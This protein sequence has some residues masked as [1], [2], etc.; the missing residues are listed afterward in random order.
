[1]EEHPPLR[2]A[3]ADSYVA[4]RKPVLAVE[5]ILLASERVGDETTSAAL[6]KVAKAFPD[7]ARTY[8]LLG[9][10]DFRAGR[11]A[12]GVERYERVLSLSA[13]DGPI[14]VP[15]LLAVLDAGTTSGPLADCL[16]QVFLKEGDRARAAILLRH[17]VRHDPMS[18]PEV[19]KQVRDALTPEPAHPGM[20]IALSEA[21]LA[22]GEAVEAISVIGQL[23][24]DD[25]IRAGEVLHTLS[26][27]SSASPEAARSA[28]ALFREL[29]SREILPV[30]SR[31]GRGEAALNA[32]EVGEAVS[33]FRELASRAPERMEEI[34]GIFE[35]LL[36]RHPET[37]EVR[38]IL[39]G[40]YLD[41]K[42]FQGATAEL[43]KIQ[44]LNPDLLAPVLTK[45][46]EVL[47]VSPDDVEIRL[48][49]SAALLLS[50]QFEEVQ[51]LAAE[52]LRL[53]DDEATAPIQLD[54]GDACLE[55][56]DVTSAVKRYYNAYRKRPS[57]AANAAARLERVLDF[58]PN[59]ALASLALG[60]TLPET[61]RV[62]DAVARL[63]EAF[64]NDPR[65]SEGVLAEL[66]RIRAVHPVSPEAALARVD[67]LCALGRDPAATE[68]IV[69]V[70][71]SRPESARAMIPRL[72]SI[73]SRN[74]GHAPAFLALA[75][76][77]RGLEDIPHAAE[78][79]RSAY[80]A[81]RGAA[82]QVIR[83]CS[84][85]IS[86]DPKAAVPYLSM[87]EIYLADGEI[88]AATEKL[89]QAATRAEERQ[90]EILEILDEAT[91]R[92]SGTARVALLA[93]EILAR[94][95]R[96]TA[97]VRSFRKAL[98]RDSGMLET[99]L[100]G[101][102][103]L[104]AK[105]G[106][107]GEALLARAQAL[108]LRQEFDPAIADLELAVRATPSLAPE[109]ISEALRLHERRP[110]SYRL[111]ALL[112]DL[113]FA[114]GRLEEADAA[115]ESELK[116]KWNPA[117][118]LTLVVRLWRVRLA[119]GE[120]AA[121]RKALAEAVT[122]AP[123]RNHL[124][125]RVHECVLS[126]V[127][128]EV[129]GLRERVSKGEPHQADLMRL[130]A[131]LLDLGESEEALNLTAAGSGVLPAA[132]LL[133][134]H[135]EAALVESD[136]FRA[137][138]ILK[139]LGPNRRL[140]FAAER[141]GDFLLASRTLEQI[142]ASKPDPDIRTALQRVYRRLVLQ[143]LEPGRERLVGETVLRFGT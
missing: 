5:A 8:L 122:L 97:A 21:H 54:L 4:A 73:L 69:S 62:A 16:A 94:F 120:T 65:I 68:A 34:R 142:A 128:S 106:R 56:G 57:L 100:S 110:G 55:R 45:Y 43:K 101:Y 36:V 99:V 23:L 58:H 17:R 31:F 131:G 53:R 15:K 112:T 102:N 143:D 98:E 129:N 93:A 80:R 2:L 11:T 3:L 111:V 135:S 82:P 49:L 63:L 46:R 74:P 130:A 35:A 12:R 87:A 40:L 51:T 127:R 72:D 67:I 6:E 140:A 14:L 107:L 24:K 138:E 75:R 25:P 124:F 81:D 86:Q 32:G 117:D 33:A 125:A 59:L 64:R 121:A 20:R 134:I 70:L 118:R 37:T 95:G 141:C 114:A 30:A 1:M 60:K 38:Y 90:E 88:A 61:G 115:L 42:N 47:R 109:A 116:R 50:R 103:A 39:A 48:G 22:A 71:E 76:A 119:R 9:D 137:S 79:C 19:V 133:K 113:L 132:D 66:D 104:L 89:F 29:G 136:Y 92:D 28:L 123:D 7:H 83:I 41:R 85:L 13:E 105:N 78:A 139:P 18:A 52:T 91:K 26:A 44:S 126:Q 84:E 77:H 10:L 27:A 96:E 108:A